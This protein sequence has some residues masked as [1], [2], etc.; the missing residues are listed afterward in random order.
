MCNKFIDSAKFSVHLFYMYFVLGELKN[1]YLTPVSTT[2][3]LEKLRTMDLPEN[4]HVQYEP[5]RFH[6][7]NKI[8][9]LAGFFYL[10]SQYCLASKLN[11]Y[12]NET[13]TFLQYRL[14]NTY[15][16]LPLTRIIKLHGNQG[17]PTQWINFVMVKIKQ[18]LT[19]EQVKTYIFTLKNHIE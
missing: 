8:N 15:S 19:R 18:S 6:P 16:K 17:W 1:F 9:K 14:S 4:L 10:F 7:G 11:S 2:T 12:K 5:I 3:P 13:I